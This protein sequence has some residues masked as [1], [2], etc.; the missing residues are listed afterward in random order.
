MLTK[1]E[2]RF[3]I[4]FALLVLLELL[5]GSHPDLVPFHY[6]TKPAIV[7]SLI[8]FFW[9]E[10]A[11]LNTPIR[12]L[13][14]LALLFSLLGDVLLMFVDRSPNYFMFGLFAFLLAHVMYILVFLKHRN[15]Q[16]KFTWTILILDLF[17][18]CLFL[19]LK[20]HLG[21]MLIP[22]MV[23]M[24]IILTMATTSF[25]RK[26]KV[27]NVSYCFV[28]I[29]AILFMMSDSILAINKFY[30][31]VPMANVLIMLTYAM[32]QYFIVFG[33]KKAS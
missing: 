25:L 1:T 30:G 28:V 10:S 24:L 6:V 9:K 22:V 5:C 32:A 14:L 23:Y 2:K 21:E 11:T 16:K 8:I 15:P 4:P 27:S 7:T 19:F 29:G 26:G 18:L 12:V 20:D 3:T 13:T 17:G 31:A 33:I